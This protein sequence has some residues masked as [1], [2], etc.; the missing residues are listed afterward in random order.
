[1]AITYKGSGVSVGDQD[2]VLNE[3]TE[4]LKSLGM[5]SD[6]LFGGA[7]D[8]TQF[9]DDETIPIGI[10]G[11]SLVNLT[12]SFESGIHTTRKALKKMPEDANLLAILD[13]Y[14]SPDMGKKV[15]NFVKGVANECVRNNSEL[16]GGETAQMPGTYFTD[17]RDAYVHCVYHGASENSIDIAPMIKG[18][19]NPYS[20]VST[21]GVGTKSRIVKTPKDIIHHS[22]NDIGAVGA[23]AVGF[24]LYVAGNT[25]KEAYDTIVAKAQKTCDDIGI[26][27]LEAIVENKPNVYLDGEVDIAGTALGVVD[28]D[29][30][31]NG[32]NSSAGDKIIGFATDCIMTNG[33]SLAYKLKDQYLK[34]CDESK[35]PAIEEDFNC[36]LSKPHVSYA[37]ILFG[38]DETVGIFT[39]FKGKIKATAHIT[40]G[41]QKDNIKRMVPQGLCAEIEKGVLPYPKLVDYATKEELGKE[42]IVYVDE[43]ELFKTFNMGVGFTVT[44]DESVA[45]AVVNYVNE[46]FLYVLPGV[47]KIADIIGQLE[48]SADGVE[49]FRYTVAGKN[50]N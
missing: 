9:K 32:E 19:K 6:G 3:I 18:M 33:Y 35:R 28:A 14:A 45:D 25:T 26:K 23:K 36:E 16:V 31:I 7:I 5:H 15:V 42:K 46:H 30:L 24:S 22:L 29:D 50:T 27:L 13:Y 17:G 41:G 43:E 38:N 10:S 37:D 49:K 44:V 39:K 20:I 4:Y 11:A 1:M 40:G 48:D 47:D 8:L 12:S 2:I 34:D 21:D